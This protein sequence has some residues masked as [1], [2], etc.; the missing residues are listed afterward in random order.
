MSVREYRIPHVINISIEPAL[1]L[2]WGV[3]TAGQ[4]RRLRALLE[5]S[6]V[7]SVTGA[8]TATLESMAEMSEKDLPIQ[9]R[10][11]PIA[12]ALMKHIRTQ[13]KGHE[14]L[15]TIL[16]GGTLPSEMNFP[17]CTGPELEMAFAKC[18]PMWERNKEKDIDELVRG[19]R[20]C[21]PLSIRSSTELRSKKHWTDAPTPW[22]QMSGFVAF[23]HEY[24]YV[25]REPI[26]FPG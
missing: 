6:H 5:T 10:I 24:S 2:F 20:S 18:V 26:R 23:K 1:A 12:N 25:I 11:A 15:Q 14:M 22:M 7:G 4:W 3:A 17:P 13:E 21:C 19:P 16:Q 8:G 9:Q